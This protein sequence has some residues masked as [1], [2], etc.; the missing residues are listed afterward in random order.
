MEQ[1]LSRIV[2][3]EITVTRMIGKFKA[4]QH[5][6]ESERHAVAAALAAEGVVAADC[7][8]VIRAPAPR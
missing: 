1:T 7:D 5:R 2:P 4:S 3:F 6:P 8:E